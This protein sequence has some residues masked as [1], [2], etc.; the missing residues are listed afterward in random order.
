M[1]N[2][3]PENVKQ[4]II[5]FC[6]RNT[7]QL[8]RRTCK[9][10]DIEHQYF[11]VSEELPFEVLKE[12]V[13]ESDID[14]DLI[15]VLIRK[16]KLDELEYFLPKLETYQYPVIYEYPITDYSYEEFKRLFDITPN[17]GKNIN[18]TIFDMREC[19]KYIT[20]DKVIL[21][22]KHDKDTRRYIEY[23][24]FSGSLGIIEYLLAH[25]YELNENVFINALLSKNHNVIE[26][27]IESECRYNSGVLAIAIQE[28]NQEVIDY[29][30]KD[31]VPNCYSVYEAAIR[32]SNLDFLKRMIEIHDTVWTNTVCFNEAA[33]KNDIRILDFLFDHNIGFEYHQHPVL[34]QTAF[35]HGHLDVIK[36]LHD[37]GNIFFD[38]LLYIPIERGHI[39]VVKWLISVGYNFHVLDYVKAIRYGYKE[40]YMWFY[41]KGYYDNCNILKEAIEILDIDLVKRIIDSKKESLTDQ[42]WYTLL[43]TR[44]IPLLDYFERET[45]SGYLNVTLL[46]KL[47]LEVIKWLDKRGYKWKDN[48][49]I[50][51]SAYDGGIRWLHDGGHMKDDFPWDNMMMSLCREE[52]MDD[53]FLLFQIAPKRVW[54]PMIF[55][56]AVTRFNINMLQWF[57]MNGFPWDDTV[58]DHAVEEEV[59]RH[60]LQWMYKNKCPMGEVG[61]KFCYN[62]IM[63]I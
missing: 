52:K 49:Y 46:G 63:R 41:D 54:L 60:I 11:K 38:D 30:T 28:N 37:K 15:A 14:N 2:H 40:L 26:F 18:T 31:F 34:V 7:K 16:K 39:E 35:R 9:G 56:T 23:A 5:S 8:L 33:K 3:L 29:I 48:D 45:G 47:D 21:L 27:L 20:L 58:F 61:R 43:R 62:F 13:H 51:I 4:H 6:D 10:F 36:W 42:T 44:Y 19:F 22:L 53:I 1:L 59:S 17:Y 12:I 50:S 57:H 32:A 25:G 24:P 55:K